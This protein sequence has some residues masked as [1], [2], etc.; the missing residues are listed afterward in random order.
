MLSQ[1]ELDKLPLDKLR[2]L[3]E[4]GS[5][6]LARKRARD[7]L[8][9]WAR[10]AGFD[11][12]PHHGLLLA[13]LTSMSG[14]HITGQPE[15][16]PAKLGLGEVGGQPTSQPTS[17][18]VKLMSDIDR[19]EGGSLS[20]EQPRNRATGGRLMVFMPPGSAKSTY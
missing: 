2:L 18:P 1:A 15:I 14:G 5:I 16:S 7:N 8:A 12:A 9:D 20:L 4:A 13:R 17:G 3:A 11:P 6:E 10:L 19:G